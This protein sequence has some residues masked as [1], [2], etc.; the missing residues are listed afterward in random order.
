MI[1]NNPRLATLVL[2]KDQTIDKLKIEVLEESN[3][4]D[5][6]I[7]IDTL[8]EFG[9][10]M[11][12]KLIPFGDSKEN[13]FDIE[14]L[15]DDVQTFR[16]ER[17]KIIWQWKIT[18]LKAGIQELKLSV[19]IIEKDGEAVMLP[20]KNIKVEIYAKNES[21]IQKLGDF[22]ERKWEF[23]LTAIMIPIIIAWFTTK[24]KNKS[25][26]QTTSTPMAA[27][28]VDKNDGV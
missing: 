8:M 14:A 19:Q 17:N 15:G 9:S 7:T 3:A 26:K 5:D 25:E 10:K 21:V 1:V 11:K 27:R 18:P 23:L 16:V 13:T 24:L 4:K 12:A 20:A 2:G 6:K 22:L 28:T